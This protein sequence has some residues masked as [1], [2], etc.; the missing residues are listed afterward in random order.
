MKRF[1]VRE[2]GEEGASLII[3]LIF[4]VATAIVVVALVNLTGT[5][6]INTANLQNE[7]S[8]EYASDAVVDGTIQVVRPESNSATLGSTT[9]TCSSTSATVTTPSFNPASP[10]NT[11][12]LEAFCF[13]S[14]VGFTRVVTIRACPANTANYG[15]CQATALLEAQVTYVDVSC[16]TNPSGCPA[17][18]NSMFINYWTVER[19]SA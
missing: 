13:A 4:V 14:Q 9:S 15:A 5:N 7:R 2:R 11:Y 1:A 16:T 19:A 6:L 12:S 3:A 17:P 10:I 18:G 8:V